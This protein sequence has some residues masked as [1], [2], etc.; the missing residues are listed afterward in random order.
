MG[1]DKL[2]VTNSTDL[3]R[4]DDDLCCGI[5]GHDKLLSVYF[6]KTFH[7]MQSV[8]YTTYILQNTATYFGNLS[9]TIFMLYT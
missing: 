1:Q 3:G 5:E 8:I 7:S 2:S 4:S 9:A 6:A